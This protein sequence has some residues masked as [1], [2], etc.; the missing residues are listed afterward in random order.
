MLCPEVQSKLVA[1]VRWICNDPL[2]LIFTYKFS[3]D[4]ISKV[5]D[6]F[7]TYIEVQSNY[8]VF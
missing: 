6:P 4:Y 1:A 8:L 5:L 3:F 2:S 7:V